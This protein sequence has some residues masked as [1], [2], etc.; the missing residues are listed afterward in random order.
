MVYVHR[1]HIEV[2]LVTTGPDSLNLK[3]KLWQTAARDLPIEV[4]QQIKLFFVANK[5]SFHLLCDMLDEHSI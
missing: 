4:A 3:I 2:F 5:S 1:T